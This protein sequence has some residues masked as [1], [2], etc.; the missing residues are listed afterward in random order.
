MMQ[1]VSKIWLR[2]VNFHRSKRQTYLD[3]QATRNFDGR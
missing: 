1:F 3:A 2:P